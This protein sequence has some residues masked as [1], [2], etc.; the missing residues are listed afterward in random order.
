MLNF[1]KVGHILL[2]SALSIG[3]ACFVIQLVLYHSIRLI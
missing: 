1:K 3:Y 2:S